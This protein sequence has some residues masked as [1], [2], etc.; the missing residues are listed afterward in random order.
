MQNTIASQEFAFHG[1]ATGG[2]C[3]PRG[4]T[5]NLVKIVVDNLIVPPWEEGHGFGELTVIPV[6]TFYRSALLGLGAM[7]CPLALVPID[8]F[9]YEIELAASCQKSKCAHHNPHVQP[10]DI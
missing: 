1:A 7:L 5:A 6:S 9:M 3:Q 8:I 10:L 4:G 2:W